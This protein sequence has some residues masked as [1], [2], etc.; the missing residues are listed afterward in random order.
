M[1]WNCDAQYF[2]TL[3]GIWPKYGAGR[4]QS[5]NVN[6]L[7]NPRVGVLNPSAFE[8]GW[9]LNLGEGGLLQLS[10]TQAVHFS[11]ITLIRPSNND[12]F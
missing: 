5:N 11:L 9:G 8:G 2:T 6:P 12:H 10:E 7:L 1:G 3:K 4:I